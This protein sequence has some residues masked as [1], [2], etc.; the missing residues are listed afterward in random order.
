[1][2]VVPASSLPLHEHRSARA[3]GGT[4]A[5]RRTALLTR[6]QREDMAQ[7]ARPPGFARRAGL[8]DK[9]A[10]IYEDTS[11]AGRASAHYG[12]VNG[13]RLSGMTAYLSGVRAMITTTRRARSTVNARSQPIVPLQS[14]P[15]MHNP[16]RE[17]CSTSR[18]DGQDARNGA[19]ISRHRTAARR[20]SRPK[21]M[22]DPQELAEGRDGDAGREDRRRQRSFRVEASET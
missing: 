21:H 18:Q 4:S 17:A 11:R 19:G 13:K 10:A 9:A 16:A 14:I 12:V 1:M 15:P 3:Q 22:I 5:I 20:G 8:V 7:S 6:R 2:T